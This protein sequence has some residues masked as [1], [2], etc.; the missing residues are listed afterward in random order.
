MM[1]I[2]ISLKKMDEKSKK[3]GKKH[4]ESSI[5]RLYPYEISQK[6]TKQ[7]RLQMFITLCEWHSIP[8]ADIS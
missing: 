2:S 4:T 3:K 8:S 5:V 7:N 1:K 6:G